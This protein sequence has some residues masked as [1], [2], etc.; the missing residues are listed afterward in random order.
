VTRRKCFVEAP[1][2][3]HG[4]TLLNGACTE[5]GCGM[6]GPL[7]HPPI[8]AGDPARRH[9]RVLRSGIPNGAPRPISPSRRWTSC[10]RTG[11][12]LAP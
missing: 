3:P 7:H 9:G 6:P 8:S 10:R 12:N 11:Q 5:I 2:Y 4:P 1:T